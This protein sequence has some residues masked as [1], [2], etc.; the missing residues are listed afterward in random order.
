[1]WLLTVNER[2]FGEFIL[3]SAVQYTACFFKFV[4]PPCKECHIHNGQVPQTTRGQPLSHFQSV[5][6]FEFVP[7]CVVFPYLILCN[8]SHLLLSIVFIVTL[9]WLCC[10]NCGYLA[11]IY[12]EL[13]KPF[14]PQP[15]LVQSWS[16]L[17]LC[18]SFST[19][20]F[21]SCPIKSVQACIDDD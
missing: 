18:F 12:L 20:W 14:D 9:V 8:L 19:S 11:F 2:T 10:L 21:C 17:V 3:Q 4:N 1:M 13:F 5:S 16:G 15:C 7:T 6:L